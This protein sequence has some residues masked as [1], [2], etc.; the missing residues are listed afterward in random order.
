[1]NTKLTNFTAIITGKK[2]IYNDEKVLKLT[3]FDKFIAFVVVMS[4]STFLAFVVFDSLSIL[5]SMAYGIFSIAI[6]VLYFHYAKK[7][8]DEA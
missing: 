5:E 6:V 3:T 8:R 4:I 2:S 7:R 1:M